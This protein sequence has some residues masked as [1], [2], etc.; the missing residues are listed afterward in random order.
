MA[1]DTSVSLGWGTG[2]RLAT[3][4]IILAGVTSLT[5]SLISIVSI[6]LQLKNYRKPLLQRYVV[7]ILIIVPIFAVASYAS[8]V[9]HTASDILDP[10]RDIYEA[11]TIYTFFQLLINFLDGERSIIIMTY[12]RPPVE[13]A[14]PLNHMLPKIDISD[15]YTFLAIKR[16]ILQYTWLKPVLSLATIIMKATDTYQEGYL[17]L[18]SGYMWCGLIYNISMTISLYALAMF[19]LIMH[20]DLRPYRPVPK[21]L[22]YVHP[23]VS[24]ARLPIK[25]AAR[26]AF[27]CV[28]LIQDTKE[29]FSGNSYSYYTFEPMGD[30]MLAHAD[31]HSRVARVLAGMRYERG[32][33]A[34]YWIPTPGQ[35]PDP[36]IPLLS[37]SRR[38]SAIDIDP[39]EIDRDDERLFARARELEFGD[40]NYPVITATMAPLESGVGSSGRR[41]RRSI[42]RK[43]PS[44][45]SQ[46]S[47][48]D[49]YF[50]SH[51][52]GDNIRKGQ[53]QYGRTNANHRPS[54][55]SYPSSKRT[56]NSRNVV[57][58]RAGTPTRPQIG[59]NR[60][61]EARRTDTDSN[62]QTVMPV[63]THSKPQQTYAS[64]YSVPANLGPASQPLAPAPG[65]AMP[66]SQTSQTSNVVID[67]PDS[68]TSTFNQ[69]HNNDDS[70]SDEHAN[71]GYN[72]AAVAEE[73]NVWD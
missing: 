44:P 55:Q 14:W 65:L 19:W 28:D 41:C 24:A 30:Q 47:T 73:R 52:G 34:K 21:F 56:G 26:D 48:H 33:R 32:G 29:T 20:N 9:S 53:R 4:T 64:Q 37:D 38:Q 10:I 35:R 11:F 58:P 12:G 2:S 62:N 50:T 36:R 40:W 17:G 7:R 13:H 61:T 60:R 15:P 18:S 5:A 68:N 70:D 16:G 59:S 39:F 43:G 31:S 8:I 46:S 3:A 22:Y 69:M 66:P 54:S 67:A 45:P 25:Y 57:G 27:G 71:S 1:D 63:F 42:S 72:F 51:R 6:W 49:G 23:Y